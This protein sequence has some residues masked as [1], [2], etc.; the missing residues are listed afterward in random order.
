MNTKM[1]STPYLY[2]LQTFG[3]DGGIPLGFFAPL[4]F[5]PCQSLS[6]CW[7]Q[8]VSALSMILHLQTGFLLNMTCMLNIICSSHVCTIQ[9]NIQVW[10]DSQ[11]I[12]GRYYQYNVFSIVWKILY[13]KDYVKINPT[14]TFIHVIKNR[15]DFSFTKL[16]CI[17]DQSIL[18]CLVSSQ[19]HHFIGSKVYRK[20]RP[21]FLWKLL[22]DVK[23]LRW[24][25]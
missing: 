16:F 1:L 18:Y 14:V 25:Q 9:H 12:N 23:N 5:C 17:A 6:G 7:G 13:I 24:R 19:H 15:G 21:I 4:F 20:H 2:D 22:K 8:N 3:S 11:Q 10:F